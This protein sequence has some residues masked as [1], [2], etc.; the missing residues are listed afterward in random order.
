[1]TDPHILRVANGETISGDMII[2]VNNCD[3]ALYSAGLWHSI[4]DKASI[5][6]PQPKTRTS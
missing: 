5:L 2:T 1:M 6:D 3:S 4:I